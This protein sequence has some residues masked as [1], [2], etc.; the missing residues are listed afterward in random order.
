MLADLS[1]IIQRMLL[2]IGE[3]SISGLGTLKLNR[4]GARY[5]KSEPKIYPP[6]YSL[7]F[8]DKIQ[9]SDLFNEFFAKYFNISSDEA[10]TQIT[11]AVDELLNQI[12]DSGRDAVLPNIGLFKLE[13]DKVVFEQ[14]STLENWY[15][16]G[17]LPVVPVLVEKSMPELLQTTTSK[18]SSKDNSWRILPFILVLCILTFM[19][20]YFSEEPYAINVGDLE[21]SK[22]EVNGIEQ[23]IDSQDTASS[24]IRDTSVVSEECIIITGYFVGAKNVLKMVDKIESLGYTVFLEDVADGTRVGIKLD[25]T[26]MDLREKIYNIR[27]SV[28]KDSWYLQPPITIE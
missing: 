17:L 20:K 28:S 9:N 5:E 3:A 6:S 7:T 12:T 10:A 16:N 21:P 14:Q 18:K 8:S 23:N 22:V 2:E 1:L 4:I 26:N 24:A 25:C 15:T 11:N 13:S 27:D 19:L